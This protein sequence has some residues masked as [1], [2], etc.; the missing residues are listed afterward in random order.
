ML[1]KALAFGLTLLSVS[2][3]ALETDNFISWGKELKDISPELNAFIVDEINEA[4]VEANNKRKVQ[5]CNQ[6]TMRIAK[7]FKTLSPIAHPIEDWIK[8][9]L[10][11]EH[12]FPVGSGYIKAS[13]YMHPHY[14]YL[15]KMPVAP[16]VRIG[17]FYLGTDKISHF[18]STGRRYLAHYLKKIKKGLS[19]EEA[20]KSAI[21]FGLG[22]EAT[23]LGSWSS[24]VFSYGDMEANYQGFLFFK[25]M[26]M[27]ESDNY[28]AQDEEGVWSLVKEPDMR[29]Y[30]SAYWDETFNRSYRLPKSWKGSSGVLKEMYCSQ[31]VMDLG[32][33]R[34]EHYKSFP[35][36]SFSL[37]Y[38][39]QLQTEGY[40][41]APIPPKE[42]ELAEVCKSESPVEIVQNSN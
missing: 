21:R 18:S 31:G 36:T 28:L 8:G 29:D 15:H 37:E 3:Y 39:K 41:R 38:I 13:I 32:A 11:E 19:P 9:N 12:M 2:S 35:H 14:F 22:Q 25:K 5:S 40:Y 23:I 7:R 10:G 16:N 24:G 17:E 4:L 26:C 42:Q 6:V 1:K 30:V 20:L 33:M 27:N 34:L